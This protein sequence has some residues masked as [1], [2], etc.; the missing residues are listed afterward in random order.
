MT[1]LEFFHSFLDGVTPLLPSACG[2]DITHTRLRFFIADL[3]QAQRPSN[4]AEF[5]LAR[6]EA[7]I[8]LLGRRYLI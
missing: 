5:L 3:N 2:T 7:T 4:R 6:I 1:G 8:D